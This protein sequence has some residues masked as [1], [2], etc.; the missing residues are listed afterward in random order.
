[1][2]KEA[3]GANAIFSGPQ[4]GLSYIGKRVYGYSGNVAAVSGTDGTLFDFTTGTDPI[5][6]DLWW[7]WDYEA[8]GDATDFGIT[9][10]LNGQTVIDEEQSTRAGG[11][12]V[13]MQIF[14]QRLLLPPLTAFVLTNT[15]STGSNVNCAMTLDG[16]IIK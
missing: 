11:G 3:I 14:H 7:S 15:T 4:L 8:M 12:R 9:L 16:I 10:T 6:L 13:I 2:A 1:M 5:L